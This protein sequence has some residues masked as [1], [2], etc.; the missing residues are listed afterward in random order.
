VWDAL[1]SDRPYRPAWPE[2]KINKYLK[3]ETGKHFDPN[4]TEKFLKLL[5]KEE[6]PQNIN[7]S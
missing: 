1:R 6:L 5:S 2:E 7:P 4:I 3:G